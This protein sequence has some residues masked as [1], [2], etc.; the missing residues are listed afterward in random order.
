MK[1]MVSKANQKRLIA[2]HPCTVCKYAAWA[3]ITGV[4]IL[5]IER[6][7]ILIPI[8]LEDQTLATF[9]CDRFEVT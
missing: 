9:R 5:D 1:P 8:C 4:S 3:A 6:R 7:E 2:R